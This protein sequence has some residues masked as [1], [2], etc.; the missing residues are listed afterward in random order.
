MRGQGVT[1]VAMLRNTSRGVEEWVGEGKEANIERSL[2][3]VIALR[4]G[5][6]SQWET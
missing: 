1:W 4:L 2:G 6:Q 5:P 3:Q